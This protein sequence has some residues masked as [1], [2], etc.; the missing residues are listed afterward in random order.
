MY[1]IFA[2]RTTAERLCRSERCGFGGGCAETGPKLGLTCGDA[3]GNLGYMARTANRR[4][5]VVREARR[6][7]VTAARR[8]VSDDA[9]RLAVA[10]QTLGEVRRTLER[11]EAA[12]DLVLGERDRAV[13]LL[14]ADGWSWSRIALEAGVSRQALM[15][16]RD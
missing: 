16:R 10:V 13:G 8:G 7:A 4:D 6:R 11:V 3:S 15:K 2:G 1:H 14:R 9:A 5:S 12:R